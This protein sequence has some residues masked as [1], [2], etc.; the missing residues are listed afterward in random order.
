M[1]GNVSPSLE[2]VLGPVNLRVPYAAAVH[3]HSGEVVAAV[4]NVL[5]AYSADS[6]RDQRLF[7]ADQRMNP[8]ICCAFTACGSYLAAGFDGHPTT[9]I[10]F[11]SATGVPIG[12]PLIGPRGGCRQLAWSPDGT[13]LAAAGA[14]PCVVLW[15]WP[16]GERIAELTA[17]ISALALCWSRPLQDASAAS[18]DL[19]FTVASAGALCWCPVR[20]A[21]AGGATSAALEPRAVDL[22]RV[23]VAAAGAQELADISSAEG[24]VTMALTRQGWLLRIRGEQLEQ[25]EC[26]NAGPAHAV[27]CLSFGLVACGLDQGRVRL[28]HGATLTYHGEL[29][30]ESCSAAGAVGLAFPVLGAKMNKPL[31][32]WVIYSNGAL[33]S[34]G[35]DKPS[36]GDFQKAV[37]SKYG[38]TNALGCAAG[39]GSQLS[40][41]FATCGGSGVQV[42]QV[43]EMGPSEVC[44]EVSVTRSSPESA[45]S[46]GWS[47]VAIYIGKV[48][49]IACGH[50]EGGVSVFSFPDM[51]GPLR[52]SSKSSSGVVGVG[53]IA[54]SSA[55]P[56]LLV[57]SSRDGTVEAH[58]FA[59][60][61]DLAWPPKK[62]S[63]ETEV[64][65]SFT[66]KFGSPLPSLAVFD[67]GHVDDD[68]PDV[69]GPLTDADPSLT[70]QRRCAWLVTAGPSRLIVREVMFG[71][72][73]KATVRRLQQEQQDVEPWSALCT[74]AS[75]SSVFLSARDG[76][77]IE[78]EVGTWCS[79]NRFRVP[80]PHGQAFNGV[81]A[82]SSS[83]RFLAAAMEASPR[84]MPAVL[85]INIDLG[86]CVST[87]QG[88]EMPTCG[89][90]FSPSGRLYIATSDGAIF[91]WKIAEARATTSE[92]KVVTAGSGAGSMSQAT[93]GIGASLSSFAEPSLGQTWLGNSSLGES[94]FGE[95]SK[96]DPS[97]R[98]SSLGEPTLLPAWACTSLTSDSRKSPGCLT[99]TAG[100]WGQRSELLLSASDLTA[101]G[102][103]ESAVHATASSKRALLP[104][105]TSPMF[106]SSRSTFAQVPQSMEVTASAVWRAL[107]DPVLP[108]QGDLEKVVKKPS[109][110]DA[111]GGGP[112]RYANEG[113]RTF[114]P[115][116]RVDPE[117]SDA[118]LS[119]A[120]KT[121]A[122]LEDLLAIATAANDSGAPPAS[123]AALLELDAILTL[124]ETQLRPL[125]YPPSAALAAAKRQH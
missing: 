33:A 34:F 4:G 23:A 72:G 123:A 41:H 35:L 2:S 9:I 30:N 124:A 112:S 18:V 73:A 44:R 80:L 61:T 55:G 62:V 86:T 101:L 32:V 7:V 87:L 26:L 100:H 36:Q 84:V 47:S 76:L 14:D 16:S 91:I 107:P 120:Q 45:H 106:D 22:A 15:C 104:A 115:S 1:I 50:S 42:L 102:D 6:Q 13:I 19:G 125:L 27:Q 96:E 49:L 38:P 85:L 92:A 70:L 11:D 5:A 53:M 90:A 59:P 71:A 60:P 93:V 29:C 110:D 17:S 116:A 39:S 75:R 109:A 66:E 63:L 83:G 78:L 68:C 52:V 74:D 40:E 79:K 21:V 82:A 8:S 46:V 57:F 65:V 25:F 69:S 20:I 43:Q 28:L 119:G 98:A 113:R 95:L 81:L 94:S 105:D 103:G 64:V 56:M 67:G 118:I 77:I 48:S 37:F 97:L 31:R 88:A 99:E 3:P 122:A 89:I 58:R 117:P 54:A 114:A 12:A 24:A 108:E 10:V 111:A 51:K 121:R